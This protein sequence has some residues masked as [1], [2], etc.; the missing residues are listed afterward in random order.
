MF[1]VI[2]ETTYR[3][4]KPLAH[5]SEFKAFQEA[6]AAR[7]GYLGT[8]VTHLGNGRHVTVTL[9]DRAEHMNAARDAIG[10]AV[11]TL[12]EPIMTAPTKL[13]G[14]GEVAYADMTLERSEAP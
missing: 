11:K 8:I 4:D 10:P 12:I 1:A 9:W 2:R 7:P 13:L 6:H 5:R 14:T 3:A